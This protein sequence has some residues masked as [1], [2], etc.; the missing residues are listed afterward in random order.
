MNNLDH[1]QKLWAE[2]MPE[3]NTAAMALIGRLQLVNKHMTQAMSQTFRRYGLTDAAFDVLATL[4]RSGPPHTLTPTQL[5]EQ[6]LVTSGSMT[7][8]LNSLEKQGL[9]RREVGITDKRSRQV[10]L[11]RKGHTL[12]RKVMAHHVATQDQLLS[13]FNEDEKARLVELL[14]C[15]LTRTSAGD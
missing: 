12:I 5:L 2:Q 9:I 11:T 3:L 10:A 8:R 4:L 13:V 7:S 14:Q 6:L 1:I 15:Y